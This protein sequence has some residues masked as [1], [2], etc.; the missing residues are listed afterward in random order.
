METTGAFWRRRPEIVPKY[1]LVVF[2]IL[3]GPAMQPAHAWSDP[4]GAH[5]GV[6]EERTAQINVV[7]AAEIARQC[8][9][10]GLRANCRGMAVYDREFRQCIIW[11]RGGAYDEVAGIIAHELKNCGEGN[12]WYASNGG[13]AFDYRARGVAP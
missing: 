2:M 11:V 6:V 1:V 9:S 7:S 4:D 12:G 3:M 5:A 10:H 13:A 8:R